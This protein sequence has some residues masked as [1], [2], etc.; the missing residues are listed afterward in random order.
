MA[1]KE[2]SI[3]KKQYDYLNGLEQALT[4]SGNKKV[5]DQIQNNYL[6]FR[7]EMRKCGYDGS[8]LDFFNAE[9]KSLLDALKVVSDYCFNSKIRETEAASTSAKVDAEKMFTQKVFDYLFTKGV[10][11]E[12]DII[13]LISNPYTDKTVKAM[14]TWVLSEALNCYSSATYQNPKKDNKT[15]GMLALENGINDLNIKEAKET[16]NKLY[17]KEILKEDVADKCDSV[18]EKSNLV[19]ETMKLKDSKGKD[20]AD[21]YFDYQKESV[22]KEFEEEGRSKG[23]FNTAVKKEAD[24]RTK[25]GL[26]E[27]IETAE[28]VNEEL[29]KAS[30]GKNSKSNEGKEGK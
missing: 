22:E 14:A 10:G 8:F 20:I 24:K 17:G 30:S 6:E 2:A 1:K 16:I 29:D 12:E 27:A 15:I 23:L 26:K 25:E 3:A 28:K 9:K 19:N 18:L 13:G 7:E 4:K 11:F 21:Y 5:Y